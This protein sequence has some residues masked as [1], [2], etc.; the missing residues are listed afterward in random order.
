MLSFVSFAVWSLFRDSFLP[1]R[2][3]YKSPLETTTIALW[4]KFRV[5]SEN[6]HE[7][8]W[9]QVFCLVLQVSHLWVICS[10]F[11]FAHKR[12]PWGSVWDNNHCIMKGFS[13]KVQSWSKTRYRFERFYVSVWGLLR[14]G[15]GL[16]VSSGT[17]HGPKKYEAFGG[18]KSMY[19]LSHKVIL[20]M[21]HGLY[22]NYWCQNLKTHLVTLFEVSIHR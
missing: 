22:S 7:R 16:N 18:R 5:D 17:Q 1:T 8:L 13:C 14:T 20:R 6:G 19:H 12:G 10:W 9:N 3:V 21:S 2:G 11:D 4:R 15:Y